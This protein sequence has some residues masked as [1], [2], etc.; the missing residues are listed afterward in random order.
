MRSRILPGLPC[1]CVWRSCLQHH[2]LQR[3]SDKPSLGREA[4]LLLHERHNHDGAGERRWAIPSGRK[5]FSTGICLVEFLGARSWQ[6]RRWVAPRWL[7]WPRRSKRRQIHQKSW[8]LAPRRWGVAH[9]SSNPCVWRQV[10]RIPQRAHQSTRCAA[11]SRLQI[12]TTSL[13]TTPRRPSIQR[14]TR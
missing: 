12:C 11:S 14:T 8:A 1:H 5:G 6:Q 10:Y 2:A 13:I 4:E 7:E 3:S 9:R